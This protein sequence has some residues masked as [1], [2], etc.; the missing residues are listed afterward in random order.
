MPRD[1][2]QTVSKHF[3]LH[4]K[5]GLKIALKHDSSFI[6]GLLCYR[7]CH[8]L[9]MSPLCRRRS[10]SDF[11][12]LFAF[13]LSLG[14]VHLCSCLPCTFDGWVLILDFFI[15]HDFLLKDNFNPS[16]LLQIQLKN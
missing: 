12:S 14:C 8:F 10:L 7:Y 3:V 6:L 13:V 15:S 2:H 16:P 4:Y 5:Y 1:L 11:S 9:V